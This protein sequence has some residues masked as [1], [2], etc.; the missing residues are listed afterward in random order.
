M[1]MALSTPVTSSIRHR[2]FAVDPVSLR[3]DRQL[4]FDLF[5]YVN[6]N[7][8][9]FRERSLSF[10]EDVRRQLADSHAQ[11]VYLLEEQR[12]AYLEYLEHE[13]PGLLRDTHIQ[14][15]V[16]AHIVYSTAKVMAESI[17]ADPTYHGNVK[18][19]ERLV[20]Q[21]AGFLCR[22]PEGFRDL[23][24]LSDADYRLHSHSVNV[25]LFSLELARHA[26]IEDRDEL[27]ALGMGALLHDIG[28]TKIDARVLRKRSP[29]SHAEFEL[30][31]KHV[32]F[33][34]E[35]LSGM[36]D[37]PEW[38]FLPVMQ[39]NEREDGS[40]YPRG[41]A[42]GQIHPFGKITAVADVF[43][44]LTTNRVF[45]KAYT[46]FDALKEM[47]RLPLDLSILR[48]FIRLLGPDPSV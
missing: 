39:H 35:L 22:G 31:K 13:L 14:P 45:K 9:L 3:A 11:Q 48:Q 41:L 26:G 44:A 5:T 30:M 25:C 47:L 38:A 29:L 2:Y 4:A 32:D 28:K 16:K 15:A 12:R 8:V 20:Q 17:L 27:V 21:I 1:G 46:S 18:C 43:D 34:M 42:G 37:M 23:V 19:A 33:G 24:K 7:M 36:K 10:T 6:G 40:G